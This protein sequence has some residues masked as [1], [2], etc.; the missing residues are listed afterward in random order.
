MKKLT[1]IGEKKQVGLTMIDFNIANK[2]IKCFLD[3]TFTN[4]VDALWKIFPRASLENLG[5]IAFLSQCI[6]GVKFFTI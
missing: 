3:T 1:I 2:G 5:G 6:Y 4:Q